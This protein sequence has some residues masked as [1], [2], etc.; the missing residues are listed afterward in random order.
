[1][2][3]NGLVVHLYFVKIG[4]QPFFHREL[5][6]LVGRSNGAE[7][8]VFIIGYL[9]EGRRIA[10][11]D[12]SHAADDFPSPSRFPFLLPGL[13]NICHFADSFFRF[14]DKEHIEEIG[15]RFCIVHTGAA[16]NNDRILI[17]PVF[18]EERNT[19]KI[20]HIQ[21][22]GVAH[23]EGHGEAQHIE[24]LHRAFGFQGIEGNMFFPHEGFHIH[25][26]RIHPFRQR[27]ISC[28]QH[29]VNNFQPQMA[30]GH[31]IDIGE[32][33]GHF[34][35]YAV[36]VLYHAVPFS[37]DIAGRLLDMHQPYGINFYRI[38]VHS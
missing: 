3:Q 9:I 13:D 8:A 25:P 28:V 29:A 20:Q 34:H 22:I 38:H 19:G 32:S 24:V 23:F 36:M 18:G 1:M 2:G 27:V 15:H 37:A 26:G 10:A 11:S 17:A 35:I 12:G 7:N 4:N 5:G 16:G 21:D 14:T 33:Q 6:R 30:H 31:F